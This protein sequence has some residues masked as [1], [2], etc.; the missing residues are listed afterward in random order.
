MHAPAV[1]YIRFTVLGDSAS[2]YITRG[3]G[4]VD[5]HDTQAQ[6]SQTHGK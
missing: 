3:A 6:D 1:D 2:S 5:A 4:G